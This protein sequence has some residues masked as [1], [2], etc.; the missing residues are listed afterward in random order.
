MSVLLLL[1]LVFGQS[2]LKEAIEWVCAYTHAHGRRF[3]NGALIH[4]E[5]TNESGDHFQI[6]RESSPPG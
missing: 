1:S 6:S 3:E 5:L 2:K 4:S